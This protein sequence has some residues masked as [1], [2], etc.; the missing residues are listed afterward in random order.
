MKRRLL[1]LLAIVTIGTGIAA[2]TVGAQSDG[3]PDADLAFDP[4]GKFESVKPPQPTETEAGT[5]EVVDVFWF[6]CP[7]CYQFL[8]HMEAYAQGKPDHVEIRRMPAVFRESWIPH[9]RA[10][11]TA[12][13][14]GIEREAHQSMFDAIHK[15]DRKLDTQ[16]ELQAFFGEL[17]I[18][19]QEFA[20]V[21]DS[22]AVESLVRKSVLM[23]QRYGVRGTP[24][25]IINGKYRT[26]GSIAGSHEI[27]IKVIEALVDK[28]HKQQLVS[29]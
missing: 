6:G 8:P 3:D 12:R 7:H 17:G 18:Q 27:V 25:V 13:L 24:T 1:T 22:F 28:E 14:L 4:T 16:D 2:S 26:S 10:F 15:Q 29:R 20:E 21:Y 11:Y 9:A 23:Q 19:A 5:V